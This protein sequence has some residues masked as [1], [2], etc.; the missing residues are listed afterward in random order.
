[1]VWVSLMASG[2]VARASQVG[3]CTRDGAVRSAGGP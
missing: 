1:M 2:L 3:E